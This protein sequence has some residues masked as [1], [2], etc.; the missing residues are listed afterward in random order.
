MTKMTRLLNQKPDLCRSAFAQTRDVNEA[1]LLVHNVM[2][3][4]IA[5]IA[6]ADID[7]APAMACA[8]TTRARRLQASA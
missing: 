2:A 4:A 5:R 3:R 8:L 6:D 1:Y 7:L